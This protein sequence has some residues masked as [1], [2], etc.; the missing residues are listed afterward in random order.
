MQIIIKIKYKNT[1]LKNLLNFNQLLKSINKYFTHIT[2]DKNNIP[3]E[4]LITGNNQSSNR[5]ILYKHIYT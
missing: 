3:L 1:N 4:R 5:Q 2:Q